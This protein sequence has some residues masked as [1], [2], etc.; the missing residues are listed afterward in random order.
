MI[1]KVKKE[2][3]GNGKDLEWGRQRE[4]DI[5]IHR[6]EHESSLKDR[7]VVMRAYRISQEK[8][9]KLM[10]ELSEFEKS[11]RTKHSQIE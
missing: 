4:Q 6:I 8:V 1:A 2:I 10:S 11:I 7:S 3:R 5:E 9:N